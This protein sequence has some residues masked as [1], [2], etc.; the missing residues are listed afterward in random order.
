MVGLL[1]FEGLNTQLV[2]YCVNRLWKRLLKYECQ[3]LHYVNAKK[4]LGTNNYTFSEVL[5]T[6]FPDF[7]G[8]TFKKPGYNRNLKQYSKNYFHKS[9]KMRKLLKLEKCNF[10]VKAWIHYELFRFLQRWFQHR[11]NFFLPPPCWDTYNSTSAQ[12]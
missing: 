12:T 3:E 1:F 5:Y 6:Q 7:G 10:A 11:V 4:W 9:E 8:H 2:G